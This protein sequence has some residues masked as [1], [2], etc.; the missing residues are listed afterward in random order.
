MADNKD[1]TLTNEFYERKKTSVESKTDFDENAE[2]CF[3]YYG[4]KQWEDGVIKDLESQGRPALTFNQTLAVIN[5]ISGTEITNRFEPRMRPRTMEDEAWADIMTDTVRYVRQVSKAEYEESSAFRDTGICGVSCLE[6]RQ[7]YTIDPEGRTLTENVPIFDVFWDPFS[8]RQNLM[9]ARWV[10]RGMWLPMDE[11]AARWPESADVL[12]MRA[13]SGDALIE[14]SPEK[15]DATR[16]NLYQT[17]LNQFYNKRRDEVL[18]WDYQRFALAPW[19]YYLEEGQKKK[20]DKEQFQKVQ[21]RMEE[22]GQPVPM[23]ATYRQREYKRSFLCGEYVLEN[24]TP[25]VQNGFSYK[26]ITGFQRRDRSGVDWFGVMNLM[27]DPQ[28]WS[29]KMLSQMIHIINT[30]PKGALM[31]PSSAFENPDTVADDWS[32]ANAYIPTNENY[33]LQKD[34]RII[35][36][37]YPASQERMLQIA[38]DA[39]PK[40]VGFNPFVVSNVSDLTRVATSA[41]RTVQQQGMV[42]LSV[43]FDALSSYREESGRTHMEYIR[44][45]MPEGKVIRITQPNGA[46]SPMGFQQLWVDG[47]EYDVAVDE[48]P[49][50]PNAQME[51]WESLQQTGGLEILMN[52][53][54][55]TPDVLVEMIP[56]VSAAVRDK[57]RANIAKQD[58]VAQVLELVA[59]GRNEEVI[60]LLQQVAQQQEAPQ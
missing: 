40:V 56:N 1:E 48:A 59:Q 2:K 10:M 13:T 50:S 47:V 54:V 9:D 12:K 55:L 33:D 41:V 53:G 31:G 7:D 34:I 21:A 18:V 19:V 5:A 43:L 42:V 27:L 16:Q 35:T 17:G 45:F 58:L 24:S 4:G 29:N 14:D 30:N 46:Q 23:F 25:L 20:M 26:F 44:H 49:Q 52:S 15:H 39:I 22:L 6:Y 38:A 3:A 8:R 36:G 60:A 51:L 37:Q 57:M 32:S 11:A 28:N